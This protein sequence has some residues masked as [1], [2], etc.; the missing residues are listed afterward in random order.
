[1]GPA[2]ARIGST[3][4]EAQQRRVR[5][6]PVSVVHDALTGISDFRSATAI[7]H[8]LGNLTGLLIDGRIDYRRAVVLAYMCQLLLQ[9]INMA[10]REGWNDDTPPGSQPPPIL[11]PAPVAAPAP[12]SSHR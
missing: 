10:K 2:G 8:V 9:S 6:A 4:L 1:M 3:H 12:A 11:P 5:S 7:N